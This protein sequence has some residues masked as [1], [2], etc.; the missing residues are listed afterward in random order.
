MD[1]NQL[2]CAHFSIFLLK[3]PQEISGECQKIPENKI[4]ADKFYFNYFFS[5][6]TAMKAF[7]FEGVDGTRKYKSLHCSFA[8]L[9][10]K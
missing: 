6:K 3:L 2:N 4:A 5:G 1:N 8:A 7:V 9:T 10:K